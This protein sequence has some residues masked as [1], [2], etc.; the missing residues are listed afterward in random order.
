MEPIEN[1]EC[2]KAI[3]FIRYKKINNPCLYK[4]ELIKENFGLNRYYLQRNNSFY[5]IHGLQKI[6]EFLQSKNDNKKNNKYI[7]YIED[8]DLF[9]VIETR[10]KLLDDLELPEEIKNIIEFIDIPGLNTNNTIF[11]GNEGQTLQ[12]IISVS[13][14]FVF[15][16]PI[17]KG[18]K[19]IS[20][21]LILQFLFKNIEV[22]ILTNRSFIDSCIFLINKCDLESEDEI[23]TEDIKKEF[24]KI[25]DKD[26]KSIKIQKYSSLKKR[27]FKSQ[28]FL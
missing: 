22:R 5:P 18:I 14:L 11:N 3:I 28:R 6:K 21:K 26:A 7:N 24:G 25:L 1:D 13:N 17:D 19:D 2:T 15:I 16:N 12:K 27:I 20:N 9:F 10:I 8:K 4:A 23:K